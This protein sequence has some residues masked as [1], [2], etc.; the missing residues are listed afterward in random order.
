MKKLFF[1][2]M[3]VGALTF[4]ACGD[5]K[6]NNNTEAEALAEA[7]PQAELPEEASEL[8]N[9]LNTSLSANNGNNFVGLLM[10]IPEKVASLFKISPDKAIGYLQTAQ[11][12]IAD[13][14]DAVTGVISKISDSDLL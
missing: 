11:Q 2:F 14:K 3:A 1:L 6:S 5:S 7:D 9:A 13:N 4:T 10:N 8:P 12:F